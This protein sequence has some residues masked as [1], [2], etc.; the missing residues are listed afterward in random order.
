MASAG[1][2]Y[3]RGSTA[4]RRRG[5]QRGCGDYVRLSDGTVL[6]QLRFHPD[7]S[8]H[9]NDPAICII[10]RGVGDPAQ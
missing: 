5:P 2:E 9:P 1:I 8:R 6:V 3:P 4:P 7:I 10:K